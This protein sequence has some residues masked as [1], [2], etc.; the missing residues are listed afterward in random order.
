MQMQALLLPM[1]IAAVG[2]FL[3]IAGIYMVR[4]GEDA[5]QKNL[6]QALARGINLSTVLVI[7]AAFGLSYLLMPRTP[8]TMIGPMPGVA[9]SIFVGLAAGWLI[10]KWTEYATSDEFTPTKNLAEQ[11]ETGPATIIIGGIADGMLSV[12]VPVIVICVG[13][14]LAFGFASGWEFTDVRY[15][16]LGIYGVGIAAVGMLSTLGITLA[17]DA[18]GPIADNAGGNAEMAGLD[19]IVRERTDALD[20]LG[21]TTAATGKGFA[22]GSAALTALALLAAYIEEVRVGFERWG[23]EI[24]KTQTVGEGEFV[25]VSPGFVVAR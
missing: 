1:A 21:N 3:S 2:I 7:V 13:T 6:L 24:V 5:T 19:P 4:T 18:Y 8:G 15:F 11:A 9:F 16:A 14:L 17:T 25:K 12:W 23:D 20:S 22:I 10:G